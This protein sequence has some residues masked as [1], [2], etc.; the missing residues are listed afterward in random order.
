[1]KKTI[2]TLLVLLLTLAMVLALSGCASAD[3]TAGLGLG[4]T[5]VAGATPGEIVSDFISAALRLVLLGV[6]ILFTRVILPFVKHTVVPYLEQKSTFNT[7]RI[8]VRAAEKKGETGAIPKDRKKI[9]VMSWLETLGITV[10]E[11][12]KEMIEAAVEELDK[13]GQAVIEA[14]LGEP[15]EMKEPGIQAGP[16]VPD[17]DDGGTD[18][19]F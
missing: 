1:M 16:G 13:M 8:L 18:T 15:E 10:T 2:R 11:K 7:I 6:T 12:E 19:F 3:I 5:Q 14:V 17:P 9:W 4:D